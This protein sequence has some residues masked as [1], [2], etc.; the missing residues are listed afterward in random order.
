MWALFISQAPVW[1]ETA[2]EI[3][4]EAREYE[5]SKGKQGDVRAVNMRLR[6]DC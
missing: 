3:I 1:I 4:A 5:R 2:R 6:R